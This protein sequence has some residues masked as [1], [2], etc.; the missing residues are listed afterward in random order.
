M[1]NRETARFPIAPRLPILILLHL[2][3]L[4]LDTLCWSVANY[5]LYSFNMAPPVVLL[6]GKDMTLGAV[7]REVIDTAKD[8]IIDAALAICHQPGARVAQDALR[9]ALQAF[10]TIKPDED[11][12]IDDTD[13]T[14]LES[15][16]FSTSLHGHLTGELKSILNDEL[17]EE[18][19]WL[20]PVCSWLSRA[21][22]DGLFT[23]YRGAA[24]LNLTNVP[25]R[26]AIKGDLSAALTE[27][28][29]TARTT[30]AISASVGVDSTQ[31]TQS[32]LP[33]QLNP[34]PSGSPTP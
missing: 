2:V 13:K 24:R 21:F 32:A 5:T 12:P 23:S 18:P 33:N 10:P 14:H 8:A 6:H 28:R 31:V 9:S 1:C 17:I 3:V 22:L 29:N 4:L 27:T 16:E 15:A 7:S 30:A 11:N 19:L 25:A 26:S 34:N 20:T